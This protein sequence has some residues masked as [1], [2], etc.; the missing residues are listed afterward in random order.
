MQAVYGWAALQYQAWTRG[1][2]TVNGTSPRTIVLYTDQILEYYIDG[3][4]HFGGDAYAFRKAPL[5][6]HLDP[7]RHQLDVR[8]VRDVRAMGGVGEPTIAV[9][10]RAELSHSVMNISSDSIILPDRIGGK[11]ASSFGSVTVRNDGYE[12][13]EI[14]RFV[15]TGGAYQ[16]SLSGAYEPTRVASGQTRPVPFKLAC[17][18]NCP[19]EIEICICS[20]PLSTLVANVENCEFV[21]GRLRSRRI[22]ESHKITYLHPAGIVSYSMLQIPSPNATCPDRFNGG[23]APVM[24]Q[25]HGAGVDADNPLVADSLN[26]LDLCAWILFPSGGTPWSGDDWHQWGFAD[27]EA[28]VRSL[29]DWIVL[30]KWRESPPP[31]YQRWLV[32]GHSNGGQ[33]AW[34]TMTHHPD[35][36]LAG[37][38]ISGYSSIQSIPRLS[39]IAR[40]QS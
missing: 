39:D 10:I 25:L 7:G 2:L 35:K 23:L 14:T 30:H 28:A 9:T 5:V 20:R 21:K 22:F 12:D 16:V 37:A 18:L 24:L 11:P 33:G 15:T 13:V 38:P 34:Y 1:W 3:Q 8:L 29:S 31:D 19:E 4:H 32:T 6:L 36:I 40:S 17:G 27:V 26:G